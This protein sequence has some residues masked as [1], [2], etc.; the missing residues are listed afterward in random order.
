MVEIPLTQL[1]RLTQRPPRR[2]GI[3]WFE[4]VQRRSSGRPA[5]QADRAGDEST[6][7]SGGRLLRRL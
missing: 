1:P 6:T 5:A 4:G 2:R 7:T 3:G